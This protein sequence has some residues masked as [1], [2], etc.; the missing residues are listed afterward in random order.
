MGLVLGAALTASPL[1]MPLLSLGKGTLAPG[2]LFPCRP[3][4]WWAGSQ[5][6]TLKPCSAQGGQQLEKF[7]NVEGTSWMGWVVPLQRA[8]WIGGGGWLF[9]EPMLRGAEWMEE[10]WL[11]GS[12]GCTV[13]CSA[14]CPGMPRGLGVD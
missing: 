3:C 8:V 14:L 13:P 10:V 9:W 2:L 1:Q 6:R 4:H 7:R 11:Q 5:G 12:S